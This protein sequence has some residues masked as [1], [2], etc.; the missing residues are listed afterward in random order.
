MYDY[1]QNNSTSTTCNYDMLQVFHYVFS[2]YLTC[3]FLFYSLH[4]MENRKKFPEGK[5]YSCA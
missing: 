5:C 4:A 3:F 1:H 2:R